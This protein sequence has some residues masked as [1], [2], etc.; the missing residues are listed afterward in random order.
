MTSIIGYGVYLPW[1]RLDRAAAAAANHWLNPA[2]AGGAKGT[3]TMA[4]WDED[5]ITLAVEA[6]RHVL[7]GTKPAVDS[8]FFAS[9]TAPFADRQNAGVVAAALELGEAIAATDIGASQRAATTALLSAANAVAA[10]AASSAL[11]CAAD[12]RHAPAA[13]A[14]ELQ[15]GD[16]GAAIL[17]GEGEGIAKLIAQGSL[18]VDFVDHYREA[19]RAYDYQWEERWVR[20]EGLKK[21]APK[22]ICA[23]L[24]K[25]SIEP[26]S[27]D[28]FIFPS[29]FRG[30]DAEIAGLVGIDREKVRPNLAEAIGDTGVPHALV[31]LADALDQASPGERILVAAF[32]Q[33]CDVLV[34]E[35]GTD[36]EAGRPRH[37]VR[38]QLASGKLESNYMRYLVFNDLIDWDKGKRA[39]RDKQTALTTLYRN[40]D[41]LMALVGGEC[42][43]CGTRQFPKVRVCVN[44][45]CNGIDSQNPYSFANERASIISWSGDHLV[46]TPDPPLHYGMIG[47]ARGGRF[48]VEF[49][50]C[51]PEDIV[52]GADVRMV[53]R[54]KDYDSPRGFRRYFWKAVPDRAPTAAGGA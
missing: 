38:S 12:R 8:I 27:I 21:I 30:A 16:A 25:A 1:R 31:M 6:G 45:N 51:E 49:A 48:L 3:R 52:S 32:G 10:K 42:R 37:A 41:M 26:G 35:V 7:N 9:T 28:H 4:S 47:F 23:L 29:S 36:I 20:D 39:E 50:D 2:L 19:D 53:F 15:F 5:S 43:N 33:G 18:T 40:R 34:F 13:S 11:V 22:A 14:Q 44:P 46:F 17:L 54:I 24:E